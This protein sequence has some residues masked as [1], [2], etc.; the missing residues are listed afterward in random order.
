MTK[1]SMPP[2]CNERIYGGSN[3]PL[4]QLITHFPAGAALDCGCGTG[5]NARVLSQMGWRVTGITVSPRELEMASECCEAVLLGDLNSGIPQEAGGPFD[6]VVFSHVL[7]HLLQPEVA[8][9]EA[10]RILTPGGRII[11]ALPNVLYWRMRI[12]FLFGEFKYAPT[13]IM[14]ETHVRFYTVQSGMEL[15]RSNGFEIL[16]TLGDGDIPIPFLRRFRALARVLD[17]WASRLIPG[18]FGAQILYV[19]KVAAF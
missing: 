9:R 4:L 17:P 14:D 1:V 11:V 19:A 6:L 13:G 15:L 3:R 7:E 18:L 5:G 8:L 12:K 16:S 10:R 2:V